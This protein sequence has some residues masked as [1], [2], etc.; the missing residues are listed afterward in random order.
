MTGSTF[1]I[2]CS[3]IRGEWETKDNIKTFLDSSLAWRKTNPL[4]DGSVL[5]RASLFLP[6]GRGTSMA[7]FFF[8]FSPSLALYLYAS[9]RETV[10]FLSVLFNL[11]RRGISSLPPSTACPCCVL[12]NLMKKQ[13]GGGAVCACVCVWR[14][15]DGHGGGKDV[16]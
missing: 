13:R 3:A 11:I 8:F 14:E 15:A 1:S 9:L 5:P 10:T 16:A 4:G 12:K 7:S 6:A 2:R